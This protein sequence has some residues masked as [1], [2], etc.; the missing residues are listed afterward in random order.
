MGVFQVFKIVQ[1]VAYR[2]KHTIFF[3]FEHTQV[4]CVEM[5]YK[6]GMCWPCDFVN[7]QEKDK[8]RELSFLSILLLCAF[9]KCGHLIQITCNSRIFPVILLLSCYNR[10]AEKSLTVYCLV[11]TKRLKKLK[12]TCSCE[13]RK[14]IYKASKKRF[15]KTGNYEVAD[16]SLSLLL[17]WKLML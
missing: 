14:Y 2:V 7:I 13:L 16:V 8:V 11:S 3:N 1:K 15:L 6:P 9:L 10:V 17:E 4:K 5:E 12:Q